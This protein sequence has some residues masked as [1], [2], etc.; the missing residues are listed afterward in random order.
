VHA[1]P[2]P[3]RLH[4]AD[5]MIVESHVVV[6]GQRRG[7]E[8]IEALVSLAALRVEGSVAVVVDAKLEEQNYVGIEVGTS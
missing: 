5:E 7:I 1:E 6:L 3:A 8:T 4:P 2:H